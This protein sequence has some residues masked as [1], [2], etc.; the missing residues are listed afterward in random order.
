MLHNRRCVAYPVL[1]LRCWLSLLISA[2]L[3]LAL[4]SHCC[5]VQMYS[6]HSLRL[7]RNLLSGVDLS[8][9]CLCNASI[10]SIVQCRSAARRAMR[11]LGSSSHSYLCRRV[12]LQITQAP[13]VCMT[14]QTS[15]Q[16]ECRCSPVSIFSSPARPFEVYCLA[17]GSQAHEHGLECI[18]CGVWAKTWMRWCK[19]LL[20]VSE[21]SGCLVQW[22]GG[23]GLSGWSGCS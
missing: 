7:S 5:R 18:L 10:T 21:S 22:S 2:M 14:G 15:R 11:M 19:G 23:T 20:Q 9:C 3:S 17:G 4:S 12:A 6:S 8:C 13:L 16:A 1:S